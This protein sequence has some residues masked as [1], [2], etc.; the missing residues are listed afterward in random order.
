MKDAGGHGVQGEL[1]ILVDD[2]VT[3]IGAALKA[4]DNIG[5]ICQ[6]IRDLSLALIA[7]TM[8]NPPVSIEQLTHN[9]NHPDSWCR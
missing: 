2:G 3:G 1:S 5:V 6:G 7:L 9:R 4:D 8:T